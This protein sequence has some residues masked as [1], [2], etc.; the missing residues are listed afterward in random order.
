MN[1]KE[2]TVEQLA[3]ESIVD[4]LGDPVRIVNVPST[5]DPGLIDRARR[6]ALA[7]HRVLVGVCRVPPASGLT[8]LLTAL[9]VT[10]APTAPHRC[11][12]ATADPDRAAGELADA[13]TAHPHAALVLA[14]LLR[15]S[16]TLEVPAALDAESLAY[17]TLLAGP[18]FA[19]WSAGNTRRPPA[20]HPDPVLV[21]RTG[22]T[23][24]ITLNRPDRHNAYGR[25][26]RD[27][28]VDA[29]RVAEIDPTA[30]RV[31]L[32]GAGP[33]FCSGGDLGEFGT[34]PDPVTAHLVR[35]GAGAAPPLHRLA[36]RVEV[37]VHGRCVGAGVELPAF[38]AR[39]VSTRD[40]TFRLP[41]L[42]MGLI[43]GA[44]G[45]VSLPR[46]IGRWRT[47]HLAGTQHA[48]DA[49]TALAWRLVDEL[50]DPE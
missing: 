10:L 1:H 30:E 50:T 15:W 25:A 2:W 21:D 5:V 22:D 35:T 39:V 49:A 12:V 47:F 28:L 9:D 3:S 6:A 29:L 38:A 33:T 40:A 4:P 31:V 20:A 19:R 43:P 14:R 34:T 7:S 37:R 36:G 8:G 48:L 16:G 41:E 11:C 17:S 45:T 27:A 18:E 42:S 26:L 13:V 23:L 46:R 24:T 32:R 44:G